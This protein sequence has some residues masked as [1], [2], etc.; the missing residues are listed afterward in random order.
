M[1]R[2]TQ[3]CKT[4]ARY[5]TDKSGKNVVP[6]TKHSSILHETDGC[7]AIYPCTNSLDPN[8]GIR[9]GRSGTSRCRPLPVGLVRRRIVEL[10]LSTDWNF[11]CLPRPFFWNI[12][13]SVER[14]LSDL[15]VPRTT[16]SDCEANQHQIYSFWQSNSKRPKIDTMLW[17]LKLMRKPYI[18]PAG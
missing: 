12:C 7:N 5:Q 16:S 8:V 14:T 6:A 2:S 3:V 4:Q 9:Q 10:V 18:I 1:Q 13:A 15:A 11:H 17:H